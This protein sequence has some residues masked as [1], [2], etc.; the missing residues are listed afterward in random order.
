ME[1]ILDEVWGNE[2]GLLWVPEGDGFEWLSRV[3][4]GEGGM[5]DSETKEGAEARG[6]V[7]GRGGLEHRQTTGAEKQ[8]CVFL[9]TLMGWGFDGG[10]WS[11][12]LTWEGG[13][14]CG[15]MSGGVCVGGGRVEGWGVVRG[16]WVCGGGVWWVG[17][18]V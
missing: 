13:G 9:E 5:R 16:V 15:G 8:T 1:C 14:V 2:E 18:D 3:V 12:C 4:M 6:L 17:W 10:V 7:N 11:V